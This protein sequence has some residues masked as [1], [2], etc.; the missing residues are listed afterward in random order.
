MDRSGP[1]N[2]AQLDVCLVVPPFDA[3]NFP[4]LGTSVLASACRARGLSVEIVYG[5]ILLASQIGYD[6]YKAV[7][8]SPMSALLGEHLF[9]PHAY[10][11]DSKSA[12]APP[13]RFPREFQQRYD[14]LAP[15]IGPYQDAMTRRI[16]ARNPRILGI[17]S[18]F[19]QN[20]AAAGLAWRVKAAAPHII[21]VMGGANV[22]GPMGAGLAGAF[23]WIDHFFVGEADSEF[24]EF[25]ERLVRDGVRPP[26]QLIA[27]EPISDFR[28]VFAPDFSDYFLA[29]RQEQRDGRLPPELPEFLTMETSRGCWWGEK[30]HCTFCGL[31]GE[32]MEFRQ[33]PADRVLSEIEA[34]TSAWDAKRFFLA[35]NIMPLNYFKTLLPKLADWPARPRL[36]YEVKANLRD[37]QIESMARAGIDAIQPGIESLSSH[38][39]KLMRKGV[40]GLQNLSLLRSCKSMGVRVAWNYL[41]GLPGETLEDY[42]AVLRLLPK[43]PH[44][45]PPS[46]LN[47]III[48]R[49][50][51]YHNTPEQ[52]GIENVVPVPGYT[53]LYPD[54]APLSDIAYHFSGS[55]S[56]PLL[57][58]KGTIDKLRLAIGV[59][60]HQWH[61]PDHL[62]VLR[63]V[64]GG[65]GQLAIADTRSVAVQGLT[66]ISRE[67][68]ETLKHFERPQPRDALEGAAAHI[69]RF[70][71][72][73][74]FLVEHEGLLLSVVTRSRTAAS[75]AAP[76]REAAP[77]MAS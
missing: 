40:S 25:C 39:L 24:P 74:H 45:Q 48:D 21:V 41:Y 35:D 58:D 3:I 9:R 18:T 15:E 56:T 73:R 52:F 37:D 11:Q 67:A 17:S 62:P 32:G 44:L 33:K 13:A 53:G 59:W 22:A 31:N 54:D 69:V 65:G 14:G 27:C 43:I 12:A 23:P 70:L 6:A 36:F 42:E 75:T 4:A 5:S 34:L 66:V 8:D 49:F 1:E 77:A 38:V 2:D 20:L 10:P 47:R 46:G 60:K 50:S 64:D 57:E 28:R 51:P 61:R 30:H 7:C 26:K 63:V 19:Q 68:F 29:L 72:D 55:Y 76:R 71:L 16:V